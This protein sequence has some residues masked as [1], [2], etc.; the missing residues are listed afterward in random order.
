LNS[1]EGDNANEKECSHST[2]YYIWNGKAVIPV[3]VPPV[4][5]RIEALYGSETKKVP[6]CYSRGAKIRINICGILKST[7]PTS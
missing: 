7:L 5:R 3:F 1:A 4:D 2:N 6:N